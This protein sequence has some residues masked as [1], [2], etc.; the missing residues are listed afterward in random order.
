MSRCELSLA[1]GHA[2]NAGRRSGLG[3]VMGR[4]SPAGS[5]LPARMMTVSYILVQTTAAS[6]LP[7]VGIIIS[8]RPV[9]EPQGG[10]RSMFSVKHTMPTNS[11]LTGI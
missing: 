3:P 11:F 6:P 1:V 10:G 4:Q 8:K 7:S 5:I 2:P 9:E